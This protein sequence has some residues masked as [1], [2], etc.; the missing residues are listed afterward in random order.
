VGGYLALLSSGNFLYILGGETSQGLSAANL[1]Y[2]AIYTT[3]V[4]IL[5]NEKAP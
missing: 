3:T 2:R 4:P 1:T 5:L